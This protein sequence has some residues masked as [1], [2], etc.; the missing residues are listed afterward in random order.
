MRKTLTTLALTVVALLGLGIVL[1]ATASAVRAQGL[2]ADPHF[3]VRR[4][5][6]WL[7]W[8]CWPKIGRA[9]V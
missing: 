9:H 5:L 4:Q 7:I 3:F 8:P 1:L 6:M 2:Y